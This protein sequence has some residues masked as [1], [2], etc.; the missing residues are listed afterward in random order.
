MAAPVSPPPQRS[1]RDLPWH[2]CRL[3]YRRHMT[4]L[5]EKALR[6]VE[7]LSR[8][9]QD[10]I[11]RGYRALGQLDGSEIVWFRIGPHSEYDRLV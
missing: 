7:S 3:R 4:G 9:E 10:A 1:S 5:L 6:R 8:E 11:G 2:A